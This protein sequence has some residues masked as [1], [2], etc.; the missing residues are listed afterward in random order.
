LVHTLV[1]KTVVNRLK[2]I[3]SSAISEEQFE[4]LSN[5]R[6]HDAMRTAKELMHPIKTQKLPTVV[7]KPDLAQAYDKVNWPLYKIVVVRMSMNSQTMERKMG[8]LSCVSFVVLINGPPTT[9]FK[10]LH[11]GCSLSPCPC[12][13]NGGRLEYAVQ[14]CNEKRVSKRSADL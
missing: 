8:Y 14:G 3:L 6:I 13:A 11:K 10:G 7:M 1:F 12:Y 5:N 2:V 4:F 9:F